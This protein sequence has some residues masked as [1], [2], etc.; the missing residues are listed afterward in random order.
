MHASAAPQ[1]PGPQ[2]GDEQHDIEEAEHE[3][4]GADCD[5]QKEKDKPEGLAEAEAVEREDR[6]ENVKTMEGKRQSMADSGLKEPVM[7]AGVRATS[8]GRRPDFELVCSSTAHV[9]AQELRG[10]DV[11]HVWPEYGSVCFE[12]S[13][14]LEEPEMQGPAAE[15]PDFGGADERRP[16]PQQRQH[17][18][19]KQSKKL[20]AREARMINGPGQTISEHNKS[21]ALR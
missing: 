8:E 1:E 5:L 17:G 10:A 4:G 18:L 21:A 15:G 2:E 19:E 14:W 9:F 12:E 16:K 20:G 13:S 3:H 7:R 11:P 6:G